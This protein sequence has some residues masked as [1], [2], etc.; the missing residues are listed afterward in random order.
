MNTFFQVFSATGATL[1][2]LFQPVLTVQFPK[3]VRPR[4]ERFRAS[5]ALT[6]DEN[7]EES[8]IA[9][10]ICELICPSE[11]IKVTPAEKRVS[12]F[13]GK[14]RGYLADYTLDSN[15]CI[16]CELCVQVCPTDS[17]VMVRAPETA[18][19]ARED[20]VLTMDKLYANEKAKPLAW[21]NGTKLCEMQ[22]PARGAPPPPAREPAAAP[23]APA[24]VAAP[25]EVA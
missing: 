2:Q 12:E 3:V 7:G 24:A 20:L 18:A 21:S 4:G 17:I 15:A 5:F 22:D 19:Y 13:S 8:C 10:S 11:I 9:C 16:Y 25:S 1:R 14:K 23:A 6:H